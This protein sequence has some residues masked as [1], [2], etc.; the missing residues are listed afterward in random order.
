MIKKTQH[1][2]ATKIL[3]PALVLGFAITI[4]FSCHKTSVIP[5]NG[6]PVDSLA[7]F[8]ATIGGTTW[9]TDSITAFLVNEFP[10]GNK[11]IT[12]TGYTANRIISMSLKDTTMSGSNDSTMSLREYDVTNHRSSAEFAYSNNP[13]Q[14]GRDLVW[15]QQGGADSGQATVT[16]SDGVGKSITGVFNFTARVIDIDSTGH[17]GRDT[18]IATNGVFKNISYSYFHHP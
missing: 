11:I 4:L 17:L 2:K 1:M 10:S 16:A 9:Q 6:I 7:L 15:Q 8:S 13:I 5:N 14:I 18:V 3:F 12:I